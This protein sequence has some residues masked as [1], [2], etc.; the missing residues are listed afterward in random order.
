MFARAGAAALLCALSTPSTAAV[1]R[2]PP[3][4]VG[5]LV[6]WRSADVV[7]ARFS[8]GPVFH[9][10]RMP[11][12][13]FTAVAATYT[14]GFDDEATGIAAAKAAESLLKSD[15]RAEGLRIDVMPA[16]HGL[17]LVARGPDTRA[18]DM[19]GLVARLASEHVTFAQADPGP[20]SLPARTVVRR[21]MDAL[22]DHRRDRLLIDPDPSARDV[23]ADPPPRGQWPDGDVPARV[24]VALVGGGSLA[25]ALVAAD[26][27][28]GGLPARPA[29]N[30]PASPDGVT[31]GTGGLNSRGLTLHPDGSNLAPGREAVAVGLVVRNG[32]TLSGQRMI[33][34]ASTVLRLRIADQVAAAARDPGEV[35]VGAAS[36]NPSPEVKP[37]VQFAP[38]GLQPGTGVITISASCPDGE[39]QRIASRFEQEFRTLARDGVNPQELERARAAYLD[40]A[41]QLQTDATYWAS[42]LAACE[43]RGY[44]PDD[45]A[46]VESDLKSFT[47]GQVGA[48]VGRALERDPPVTIRIRPPTKPGQP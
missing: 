19:L 14:P 37:S 30:P 21:A 26:G 24:E 36:G 15:A 10:K 1:P 39:G 25:E 34:L 23:Q 40:I 8:N 9:Y 41:R 28:L 4:A 5:E 6:A 47:T 3:S 32:D 29:P 43:T 44:T 20:R 16:E 13:G 38:R 31:V 7:T 11:D 2:C 35:K 18:L 45:L 46:S 12:L 27:A 42:V 48:L 17:T 33:A 22:L